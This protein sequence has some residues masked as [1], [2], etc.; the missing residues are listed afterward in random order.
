MTALPRG[1]DG[2]RLGIGPH[3]DPDPYTPKTRLA[4]LQSPTNICIVILRALPED[5]PYDVLL[6][7]KNERMGRREGYQSISSRRFRKC[8]FFLRC[9]NDSTVSLDYCLS[10]SSIVEYT[11]MK[12][13]EGGLCAK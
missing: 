6:V 2:A 7:L 1:A 12:A 10:S 8:V 3:R 9:G 4:S 5:K 11:F 13:V